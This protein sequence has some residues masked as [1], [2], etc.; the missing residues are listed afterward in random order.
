MANLLKGVYFL[1]LLVC[2]QA[3]A[4]WKL[5]IR[6]GYYNQGSLNL[7]LLLTVNVHCSFPFILLIKF[8]F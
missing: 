3:L 8:T 7:H 2:F 6:E 1:L 5:M 4:S